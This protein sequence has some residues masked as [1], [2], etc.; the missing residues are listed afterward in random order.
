M[1]PS[2]PPKE[3]AMYS[4]SPSHQ[5]T[6]VRPAAR[7]SPKQPSRAKACDVLR[8]ILKRAEPNLAS[9]DSE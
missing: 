2:V 3:S 9:S 7:S 5:G 8:C 6:H 4:T 1:Q